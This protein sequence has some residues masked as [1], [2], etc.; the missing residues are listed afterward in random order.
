LNHN[1]NRGARNNTI[2]VTPSLW[3]P[4]GPF[5]SSGSVP[6]TE[7]YLTNDGRSPPELHCPSRVLPRSRLHPAS[8]VRSCASSPFPTS[9]LG[10]SPRAD[11]YLEDCAPANLPGTAVFRSFNRNNPL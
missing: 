10:T 6:P 1:N 9:F 3:P 4:P 8:C 5:S 7:C 2:D 11:E